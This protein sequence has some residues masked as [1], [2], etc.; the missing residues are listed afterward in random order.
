E[1]L[2]AAWCL[3][4]EPPRTYTVDALRELC[5]R[6]G[7][8][9]MGEA[10]PGLHVIVVA[11]LHGDGTPSGTLVRVAD[12]WPIGEG[13]R[14]TLRFDALRRNFDAV[15]QLTGVRACVLHAGGA[16]RGRRQLR[17]ERSVS[18]RLSGRRWAEV[19]H[20]GS[21][22]PEVASGLLHRPHD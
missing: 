10:S 5:E 6:C 8:L 16:P 17:W 7:P 21:G 22:T 9:W 15:Q 19:R 2:A 13:E 12:P 1:A 11:G 20:G 14:Y 3:I 18:A 4:T